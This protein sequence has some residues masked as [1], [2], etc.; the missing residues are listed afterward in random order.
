[1]GIKGCL[2]YGLKDVAKTFYKYGYIH[3]IWDE[4]GDCV[5]G[6]DAA[7]GAYKVD[8]ETRKKNLPFNQDPLAKDII[9]YNEIDCKVLMEIIEY[10]RNNHIDPRDPDIN[11]FSNNH[12]HNNDIDDF[13]DYESDSIEI[14]SDEDVF[15][16]ITEKQRLAVIKK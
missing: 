2:N 5:D 10:L 7:I 14:F 6:A 13:I 15:I 1:M 4:N 11:K 9:K 8:K 12:L 16:N 3:T